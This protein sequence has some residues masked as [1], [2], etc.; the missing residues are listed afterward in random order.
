MAGPMTEPPP[1]PPGPVVA[2][3]KPPAPAP[4]E[5]SLELPTLVVAPPPVPPG[6]IPSLEQVPGSQMTLPSQPEPITDAT[7]NRR[8]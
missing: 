3:P 4:E 7:S 5:A 1:A 8:A 2:P 6:P